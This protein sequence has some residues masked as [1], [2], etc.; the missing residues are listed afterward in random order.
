M[1]DSFLF[2]YQLH[3][4]YFSSIA[5]HPC[6]ISNSIQLFISHRG[7]KGFAQSTQ[8]ISVPFV[9]PPLRTLW[10]AFILKKLNLA[11]GIN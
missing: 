8:R 9:F 1:R 6:A 7:H 2:L 4:Y 11:K 10:L 3:Y 5:S